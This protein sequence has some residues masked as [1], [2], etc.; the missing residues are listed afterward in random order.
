MSSYTGMGN[1]PLIYTDTPGDSIILLIDRQGAGGN[2][3]M[4]ILFQ[5][6]DGVWNYASQGATGAGMPSS[7][8][9]GL[10]SSSN[11]DGGL[12]V[13]ALVDGDGNP[14]T[15]EQAIDAAKN[16]AF[17][18]EYDETETIETTQEQDAQIAENA[19]NLKESY[20]N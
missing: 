20:D 19:A 14:L 9:A 10:V 6:A 11:A 4:G 8:Q 1:N 5:D 16:G 12:E 15:S 7:G 18:Y 3:H 2:G 17:G 13:V